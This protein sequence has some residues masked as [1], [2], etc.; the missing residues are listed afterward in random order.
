MIH[1]RTI[2]KTVRMDNLF[3]YLEVDHYENALKTLP[4]DLKVNTPYGFKKIDH[5]FRTAKQKSVTSYFTNNK[6]LKTSE[7]H[8]IM[9]D[10][11]WK[12][13]KD[14]TTIDLVETKEGFTRLKNKIEHK[15]E[16]LYDI[17]VEDV[18]CYYSNGILSHNSWFLAALGAHA[19]KMGKTVLHYTLELDDI[20]V[21]QR[22]DCIL[23]GIPFSNLKFNVDRVKKFL[24]KFEGKLFIKKF[25]PGTLSLQ[26][27]E[28]HIE[29]YMIKKGIVPDIVIL[30]YVELL[31]IP[32]NNQVSEVRVLGELY[33]DLKGLAETKNV[34]LWSA[35]QTN[36]A[37]SDEDVIENSGI[38]NSYAK[39]FAVDFLMT[40]S[41]K[42]KDKQ[43]KTARVHVSKSRLGPD[44][45]TF[46]TE[47]DTDVGLIKIHP[48]KSE[49]GKK[50]QEKMKSDELYDKQYAN[51]KY[52]QY[53]NQTR[54]E[55][56]GDMF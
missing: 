20:Y 24:E 26:G 38:S 29:K 15:P 51:E 2:Q 21:A 25:P 28:A 34:A 54:Q 3:D 19:L 13:V 22:Y 46:P 6:T 11:G 9:T 32:F 23:T 36:R 39:L 45:L 1:R 14:L 49:K 7:N 37:A 56:S 43:D 4:F 44:G 53:L 55:P 42:M 47:M 10:T 48:P 50:T 40:V 12:F 33:K 27:L 30:D 31:K 18:H 16:I 41:R 17:A 8:R 5:V 35:D 52:T